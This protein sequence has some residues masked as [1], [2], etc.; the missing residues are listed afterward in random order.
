MSDSRIGGVLSALWSFLRHPTVVVEEHVLAIEGQ[1]EAVRARVVGQLRREL[2]R[3]A[4]LL[5][6]GASA[7]LLALVGGFFALL[8]TWLGLRVVLGAV[9]ASF[10]MA[11]VLALSSLAVFRA[12]RFIAHRGLSEP[13]SSAAGQESRLKSAS[14]TERG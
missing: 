12:L 5:L 1:L 8:G 7:A 14:N 11:A 10:L 2:R 6:L 9:G 13:S 3:A 4:R